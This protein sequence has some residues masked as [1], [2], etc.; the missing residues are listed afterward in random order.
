MRGLWIFVNVWFVHIIEYNGIHLVLIFKKW[1][2]CVSAL[3]I[4]FVS[5]SLLLLLLLTIILEAGCSYPSRLGCWCC[6][7]GARGRRQPRTACSRVGARQRPGCGLGSGSGGELGNTGNTRPT[8]APRSAAGCTAGGSAPA[9]APAARL[10]L[11]LPVSLKL[12]PP[13]S[14]LLALPSPSLSLLQ[15]IRRN[16]RL[17]EPLDHPEK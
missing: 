13:G 15:G 11:L 16:G 7:P 6:H 2:V 17:V 9:T 8:P 12:P 4:C 3:S 5:I 1:V 14:R 10:L